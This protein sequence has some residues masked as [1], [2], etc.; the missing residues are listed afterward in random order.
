VSWWT[1]GIPNP[2]EACNKVL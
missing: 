2:N 1:L